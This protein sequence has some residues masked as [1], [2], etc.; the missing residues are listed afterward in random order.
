ML[1]KVYLSWRFSLCIWMFSLASY[2]V[3]SGLPVLFVLPR[4]SV[5]VSVWRSIDTGGMRSSVWTGIRG[6]DAAQRK[7]IKVWEIELGIGRF[8]RLYIV[9]TPLHTLMPTSHL[10]SRMYTIL[11]HKYLLKFQQ[12]AR[13]YPI[14]Q[15]LHEYPHINTNSIKAYMTTQSYFFVYIGYCRKQTSP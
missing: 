14:T 2:V 5:C 7:Q 3:E 8:S 13:T 12:S 11:T 4:R 6:N 10:H 15:T 1:T 9:Q